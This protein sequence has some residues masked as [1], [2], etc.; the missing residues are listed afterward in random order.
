[1]LLQPASSQPELMEGT[2]VLLENSIT[3]RI[4]K[5]HK[6]MEANQYPSVRQSNSGSQLFGRNQTTVMRISD[7]WM[8]DGTTDRRGRLHTPQCT[9]SRE[10]RQIVRMAVTDHSVTSRTLSQDISLT[11]HSVSEHTIRHRL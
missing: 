2:V 11:Y 6:Q 3:V 9:T 10:N 4:T 8:Q 7:H 5:E 1:M